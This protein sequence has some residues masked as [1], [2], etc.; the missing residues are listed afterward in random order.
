MVVHLVKL[1]VG[2]TSVDGLCEYFAVK[3]KKSQRIEHVTRMTP[4]RRENLLAGGSLYWVVNGF[5]SLRQQITALESRQSEN[6]RRCAIVLDPIPVLTVPTPRRAFQGWRY[7]MPD[8][9]PQDLNSS[10]AGAADD[11]PAELYRRLAELG[12]L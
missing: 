1:A 12:L 7:L 8:D 10:T 6:G 9:A 3:A 4:K 2:A 11:I 5:I